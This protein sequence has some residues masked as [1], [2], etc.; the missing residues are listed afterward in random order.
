MGK[1]PLQCKGLNIFANMKKKSLP[2][3]GYSMDLVGKK[4][5]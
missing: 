3:R 2:S 5:R 1:L 4:Q